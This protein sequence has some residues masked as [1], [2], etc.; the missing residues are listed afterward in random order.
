MMNLFR[1]YTVNKR[2]S[3]LISMAIGEPGRRYRAFFR[4]IKYSLHSSVQ[5]PDKSHKMCSS[6]EH[7]CQ[8]V[9]PKCIQ[10]SLC[11]LSNSQMTC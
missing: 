1:I 4:G 10:Y 6:F 8:A 9:P 5:F 2:E 3:A 11:A 7:P